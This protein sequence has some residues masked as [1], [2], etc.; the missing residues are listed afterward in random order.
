MKYTFKDKRIAYHE[1]GHALANFISDIPFEYVTIIENEGSLGHLSKPNLPEYDDSLD[2]PDRLV[3]FVKD[4]I[5]AIAGTFSESIFTNRKNNIGA[6]S[7]FSEVD[8]LINGN[9]LD[10]QE[11]L[12]FKKWIK[13]H[14]KNILNRPENKARIELLVEELLIHKTLTEEQVKSIFTDIKRLQKAIII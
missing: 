9:I 7:D 2:I 13:V 14:T 8:E 11:Q 10:K 5:V 1:A 4:C 12:L 3:L 6:S